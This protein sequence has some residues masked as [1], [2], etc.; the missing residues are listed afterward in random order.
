MKSSVRSHAASCEIAMNSMDETIS[1]SELS[2][3]CGGCDG[4]VEVTW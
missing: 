3:S 2:D 4:D 1:E